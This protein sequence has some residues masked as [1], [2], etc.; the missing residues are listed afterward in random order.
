MHK[1][2]NFLLASV[3]VLAIWTCSAPGQETVTESADSKVTL[4][5]QGFKF[6]EGPAVNAEGVVFFTDQ[7]NNRIVK[8][9]LDG[10]VSDWLTPSGRSNGM[11][12]APDGKLIAC[13]DELNEMWEISA[14]GTHQV[15]FDK[16]EDKNLNGPNDVWV[17]S[18]GTM[19]FTDPYYQRP[20]WTHQRPPQSKQA[21]YKCDRDGS[22]IVR[23][24]D[25][26]VQPNG[27]IGD[28]KKRILYVAD[29]GAGKTYR[30]TISDDGS[31]V[32]RKLFCEQGSDGMTIDE[33]GH[34]YLT[35]SEGVTVYNDEGVKIQTI[36]VPEGWTANVCLGGQDRKTM[37]ITA[38]DSVY[39]IR[40][41]Y[42]G[43]SK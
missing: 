39:R 29:I 18:D 3:A 4:V 32:D 27:I 5:A 43:I 6:T 42:A 33:K 16:F 21:V 7:P 30:Y 1:H 11:H 25:N 13:A 34:V 35:G 24:D 20:W 38:S 15:L 2:L 37:Y 36:A 41:K 19:Y 26:V 23:V 9:D 14:D 31:L 22:N 40:V 10:K 17:N 8:I 12:F 28:A